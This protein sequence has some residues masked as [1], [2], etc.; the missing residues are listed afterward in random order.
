MEKHIIKM[1]VAG[2]ELSI[3]TGH[4]ALAA[5]GAVTVRYGDT[6]VLSTA[7]MSHQGKEGADFF[8]MTGPSLSCMVVIGPTRHR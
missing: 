5:D 8:P 1:E 3:E 7:M 2:R 4:F 6:V